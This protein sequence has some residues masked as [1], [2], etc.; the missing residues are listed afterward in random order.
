MRTYLL[1]GSVV[2]IIA[3]CGDGRSKTSTT[4]PATPVVE[5]G[6]PVKAPSAATSISHGG[7]ARIRLIGD[8]VDVSG[9]YPARACGGPFI[10]N[11]GFAY[12]AQAGEWQ[13][14][15][16]SENRTSGSVPLDESRDQVNVSAVANGPGR[17]FARGPGGAGSVT[18]SEDFLRAEAQL[19]LRGIIDRKPARLEVTFVCQGNR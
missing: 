6:A 2:V 16:A 11:D 9:E 8:G 12:Q 1:L 7:T 5:A 17:Q 3:A 15:V 10:K 18:I 4:D 14:L 19:D 13:I